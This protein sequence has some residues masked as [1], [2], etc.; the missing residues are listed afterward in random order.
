LGGLRWCDNHD[1]I[2]PTQYAR[3]TSVEENA[4]KADEESGQAHEIDERTSGEYQEVTYLGIPIQ[5]L[6]IYMFNSIKLY[7]WEYAFVRKIL[8][9]RN[10]EEL[11]MLRKIGIVTVR[12]L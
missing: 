11:K 4:R 10:Q 3:G 5:R 2:D 6:M 7:A 9:V 1:Y 8:F 12:S